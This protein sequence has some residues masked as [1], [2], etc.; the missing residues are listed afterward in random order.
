MRKIAKLSLVAAVAIAGLTTANA[1]SLEEAIKGVDVSG[2]VVYRYNDY[3]DDTTKPA[4]KDGTTNYYKAV[5]NL[6][7]S[8]NDDMAAN[9]SVSA[10]NTFGG[11][12]TSTTDDSNV[13]VELTKVNFAYTGVADT[14]VIVGKMGVPTPWTVAS[15]SDGAEQTGTGAVVINS[16][17]PVTLIGAYFN[18]TNFGSTLGKSGNSIAVIGAKTALSGVALEAFYADETDSQQSYTLAADFTMPLDAVKLGM[19]LR[20]TNLELEGASTDNE[21]TKGYIS[22]KAGMFDAKI[23]YG[24]TGKDGGAVAYDASAQTAME[25]WNTNLSGQKNA[26][27]LQLH[28][29]AQV[30]PSLNIA[31]NHFERNGDTVADDAEELYTQITYKAGKNFYTYVRLGQYEANN[32]DK[33]DMGRLQVQY[34]F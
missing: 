22:A 21:L 16:S 3:G 29:G 28:V 15:D 13:A 32:S 24:E 9:V 2:T 6:K 1:G 4:G 30:L 31:L 12:D 10:N 33:S 25:G 18:Q 23:A 34:S 11:M 27:Y 17:T 7:S 5:L 14:T 8:I 26:D 19:G 20:Y